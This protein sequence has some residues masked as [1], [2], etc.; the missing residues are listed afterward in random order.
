[1]P[2]IQTVVDV[3]DRLISGNFDFNSGGLGK[4]L[5]LMALWWKVNGPW[6]VKDAEL[7]FGAIRDAIQKVSAMIGP[8]V[9]Q[10][11]VKIGKWFVDN[12]PTIK[13]FTDALVAAFVQVII[14]TV[15]T[16]I[17]IILQVLDWLITAFLGLIK[18]YM[19]FSLKWQK[20]WRDFDTAA[21]TVILNVISF[22]QNL[23]DIIGKIPSTIGFSTTAQYRPPGRALGGSADGLTLVGEDGPEL[24]SL[25][26]GSYVHSNRESRGVGSNLV[27]N[28]SFPSLITA[29]N[30]YDIQ[31]VVGGAVESIVRKMQLEGR[32]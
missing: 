32:I 10:Q 30:P 31:R 24:V 21:I 11:L 23:I 19:D 16:A 18:F 28:V 14:P 12:E 2:A 7:L 1:V 27:V 9:E 6:I 17:G 13:Q 3:I 25:P 5:N 29:A 20:F 26:S 15:V 8:F 22:V 4:F